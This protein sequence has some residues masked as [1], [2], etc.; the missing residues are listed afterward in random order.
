MSQSRQ[1][2]Q[3]IA[4]LQH[5]T[6]ATQSAFHST[7][8]PSAFEQWKV[9][10]LKDECR[11]LGLVTSRTKKE[12]IA[13]L[14]DYYAKQDLNPPASTKVASSLAIPIIEV[15]D[16]ESE[17]SSSSGFEVIH[18]IHKTTMT[19]E[20]DSLVNA[21]ANLDLDTCLEVPASTESIP[22]DDGA[23]AAQVSEL[24]SP[25]A[26]SFDEPMC[27]TIMQDSKLY[28]RILLMEPISLDE[29]LGVARRAGLLSDSTSRNRA[30]LRTWLDSQGICFY[31]SD[32]IG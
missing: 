31:E 29:F 27:R 26:N 2:S 19:S 10:E 16:S 7:S 5:D 28:Q 6:C 32:N 21:T 4:L 24:Y 8:I 14:N 12:L 18:A 3:L 20:M 25:Y 9:V 13:L 30:N 15:S 1:K 17:G 11:R 22:A 23:E